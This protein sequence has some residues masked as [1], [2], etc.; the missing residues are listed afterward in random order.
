MKVPVLKCCIYF[1]VNLLASK[2]PHVLGLLQK[3]HMDDSNTLTEIQN[4]M[5]MA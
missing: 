2:K 1:L 3:V 4:Q 5:L